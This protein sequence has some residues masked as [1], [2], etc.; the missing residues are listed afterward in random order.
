MTPRSLRAR[1][2]LAALLAIVVAVV[3]V[4]VGVDVLVG[5]HLRGSLDRSLRQR[6]VGVAY[7]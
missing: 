1:S 5:R 6:A 4:G 3:S 7:R 2:I